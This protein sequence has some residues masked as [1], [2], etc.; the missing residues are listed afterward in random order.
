M[1]LVCMGIVRHEKIC[2]GAMNKAVT[3]ETTY[4]LLKHDCLSQLGLPSQNTID[5]QQ[6]FISHGSRGTGHSA[7]KPEKEAPANRN[8]TPTNRRIS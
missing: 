1:L 2:K 4:K 5:R 8:R 6:T 3:A 7:K